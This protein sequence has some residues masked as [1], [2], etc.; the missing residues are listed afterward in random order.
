MI[1]SG[2]LLHFSGNEKAMSVLGLTLAYTTFTREN[3]V[4][5]RCEARNQRTKNPVRTFLD[6]RDMK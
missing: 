1:S 5:T 2:V 4:E 6:F 3:K